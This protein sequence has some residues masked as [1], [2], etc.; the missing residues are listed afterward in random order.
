MQR[1]SRDVDGP[2]VFSFDKGTPNSVNIDFS[3]LST[4]LPEEGKSISKKL[5]NV[6]RK[7][8]YKLST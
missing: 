1:N 7:G 5:S 3:V 2:M 8:V 4:E 6:V